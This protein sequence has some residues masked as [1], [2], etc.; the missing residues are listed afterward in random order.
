METTPTRLLGEIIAFLRARDETHN[1]AHVVKR[2]RRVQA[3]IKQG[4]GG[5]EERVELAVMEESRCRQTLA[6]AS[7]CGGGSSRLGAC[8][9]PKCARFRRL[10]G[11]IKKCT[12]RQCGV[13]NCVETT[14]HYRACQDA[15][16]E[17]CWGVNKMDL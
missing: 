5:L 2:A 13:G 9:V 3:W 4:A 15:A 16:C 17:V 8:P 6:H 12:N 7:H 10:W 11:H 1:A 14:G